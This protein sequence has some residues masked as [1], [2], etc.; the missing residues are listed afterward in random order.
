MALMM[1]AIPTCFST[2]SLHYLVKLSLLSSDTYFH[3][4][5]GNCPSTCCSG[6]EMFVWRIL[7]T[8]RCV[9]FFLVDCCA[10][11]DI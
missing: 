6:T 1:V 4:F 7:L 2:S 11:G 3:H 9:G 8:S 5:A 10:G